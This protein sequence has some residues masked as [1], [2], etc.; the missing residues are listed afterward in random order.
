MTSKYHYTLAIGPT[1]RNGVRLP[2]YGL[3]VA[4]GS[5][6]EGS[7][8]DAPA[9]GAGVVV[10]F[11][12]TYPPLPTSMGRGSGSGCAYANEARQGWPEALRLTGRVTAGLV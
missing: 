4:R 5:Q 6:P 12:T 9:S 3:L 2:E 11:W 8:A 10:G 7:R 1:V